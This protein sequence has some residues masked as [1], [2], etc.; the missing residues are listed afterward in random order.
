MLGV[1]STM[2]ATTEAIGTVDSASTAGTGL[3]EDPEAHTRSSTSNGRHTIVATT[4]R[5]SERCGDAGVE[6]RSKTFGR[7]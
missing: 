7:G 6:D 2:E 5:V 4:A 1:T 3:S